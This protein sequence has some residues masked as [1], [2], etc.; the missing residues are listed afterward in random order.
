MTPDAG[1]VLYDAR[2]KQADQEEISDSITVS[3]A[4]DWLAAVVTH[5]PNKGQQLLRYYG[6]YSNVS[7][8]RKKR[9]ALAV[10]G[11]QEEISPDEHEEFRKQ[12][13]RSWARLIK[14]IYLDDPLTCP[15]CSGRLRIISFIENPLVI[16]KI[17]RHLKLG[18]APERPPP[19]RVST[20][21]ETDADFLAWEA[22]GRLFDGID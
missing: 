9:A 2:K 19:P 3:S 7:Q 4:L 22:T 12:R 10:L 1:T 14:K 8:A 21:L 16:E 18:D 5:I 6:W 20:T 17:L 11:Q 13:R 15:K